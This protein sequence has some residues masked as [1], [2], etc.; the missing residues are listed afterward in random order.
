M[1]T[2][3]ESVPKSAVFGA[4]LPGEPASVPEAR[5]YA[6]RLL[7]QQLTEDQL[8]DVV[9]VVSE[10]V[11]NAVLHAGTP[12]ITVRFVLGARRLR[13]EVHDCSREVPVLIQGRGPDDEHGRGMQL[14]NDL[15]V[16]WGVE[17]DPLGHPG[18]S[19]WADFHRMPKVPT[20]VA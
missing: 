2:G 7:A 3:V 1:T 19:V 17:T 9:L 13:V 4:V 12:R 14:V 8:G 11:S 16:A 18:K 6:K 15:A 20:V 10:L 5:H